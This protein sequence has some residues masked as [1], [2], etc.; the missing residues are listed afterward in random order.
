MAKTDKPPKKKAR[1]AAIE[2]GLMDIQDQLRDLDRKV[3]AHAPSHVHSVPTHEPAPAGDVPQHMH[4]EL[5]ERLARLETKL[6][7]LIEGVAQVEAG[8]ALR[9][10]SPDDDAERLE[11]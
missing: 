8:R 10:E 5:N 6:D 3:V 11:S 7:T 1:L 9:G 2:K 4:A